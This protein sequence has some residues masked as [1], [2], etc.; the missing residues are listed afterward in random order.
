MPRLL[1]LC[2]LALPL[3]LG[4]PVFAADAPTSKAD[5]APADQPKEESAV[6]HHSL[7]LDGRTI[8]YTATAGT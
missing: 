5:T 3:A 1:A 8:K 2:C 6:T 4:Q 7:A